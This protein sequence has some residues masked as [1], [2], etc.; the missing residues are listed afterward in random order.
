MT[1]VYR[2]THPTFGS[3]VVFSANRDSDGKMRLFVKWD[4]PQDGVVGGWYEYETVALVK[5]EDHD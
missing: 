4:V 1:R 3:G 5:G 2:V